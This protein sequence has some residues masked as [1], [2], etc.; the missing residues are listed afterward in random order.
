MSQRI[1]IK[2]FITYLL[3]QFIIGCSGNWNFWDSG[4]VDL[5]KATWLVAEKV[6]LV[7]DKGGVPGVT[8]TT[9]VNNLFTL[10]PGTKV[11]AA[12]LGGTIDP[13]G[14]T[15][16]NDFDGDGILNTDE[17]TT[18]VWVADYPVI[19]AIVAP[20]VTMKI[21]I[22]K[23]SQN[24]SDE[25][26]SEINSSDFESTK[27]QGSERIHQNEVNL[28]TVQFQ[29]SYASSN[30]LSNSTS[31]SMSYG[32]QTKIGPVSLGFNYASS[33]SNSWEAK[34]SLSTTTTKWADKPFKNNID[35]QANNLKSSSAASKAKKIQIGKDPKN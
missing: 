26:T 5:S 9:P 20:P 24:T 32:A 25:I 13:T 34:N 7:V 23:N 33:N 14:T 17:T 1:K 30:E 27:N 35:T 29:D 2:T 18:N 10:P 4:N 21:E 3:I 12:A 8:P 22:L 28:R 19:E 16:V 31:T 15:I 11:K 6:P